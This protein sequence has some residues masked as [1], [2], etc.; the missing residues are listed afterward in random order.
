MQNTSHFKIYLTMHKPQQ[1]KLYVITI[2]KDKWSNVMT[3]TNNVIHLETVPLMTKIFT[4][5]TVIQPPPA[6]PMYFLSP[7]IVVFIGFKIYPINHFSFNF[8]LIQPSI[9]IPLSNIHHLIKDITIFLS[10]LNQC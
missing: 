3:K 4:H 9:T 7:Q 8:I 10:K 5:K 1:N 2:F 6:Y